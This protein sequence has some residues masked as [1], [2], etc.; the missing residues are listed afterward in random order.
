VKIADHSNACMIGRLQGTEDNIGPNAGRFSGSYDKT[1]K[2]R[3]G[4]H[5][6]T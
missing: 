5:I 4:R 1:G 2:F 3:H 6:V